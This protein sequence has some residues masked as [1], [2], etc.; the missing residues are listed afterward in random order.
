MT[1][2]GIAVDGPAG[3][4]KS[5][6]TKIVA[7][8]LGINYVD[9]GSLYRTIAYCLF[10]NDIDTDTVMEMTDG[11][12]KEMLDAMKIEVEFKDGVQINHLNGEAIEDKLLRSEETSMVASKTSALPLVREKVNSVILN[13]IK[14]NEVIMEGRD[15]GTVV[16][17]NALLKVYLDASVEERAKRRMLEIKAKG[18]KSPKLD[19]IKADI[20]KRD[21]QDMTR[22]VAPLKKAEDAMLLDS[23]S[24]TIDEVVK[25]VTDEYLSRKKSK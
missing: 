10:K 23:T 19:D 4:G 15:I 16:M 6:I 9:S 13:V 22:D 20:E 3:A 24:L 17:P 8:E 5:T 21:K 7:K 14:D 1:K 25:F 12:L 2:K 18:E 11:E